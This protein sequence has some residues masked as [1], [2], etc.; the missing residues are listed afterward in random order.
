MIAKGNHHAHG[1]KLADYL[2]KADR[3]ERAELIETRGFGVCDLRMGFLAEQT[4]AKDGTKAEKPFFHAQ[5]RGAN[6]EGLKLSQAQWLEIADRC[7]KVL[8]LA[9]QPRA[10]SLHINRK[11]GD[12]HLHLGYSLVAEKENGQ[13]YVKKLGLHKLKLQ[14]L[15]RE[16]ERDYGLQIVRD[17][18]RGAKAPNRREFEESRRLGTSI[19]DIRGAI[20]SAFEKSD[21]GKS[22]AAAMQAQGFELANGDRRDCLVVV[23]H[24][25]GQHALNKKLTGKT[26]AEIQQ[27]LGDLDR[28]QLPSVDQ[29][30]E[31]QALRQGE[32]EKRQERA[33]TRDYDRGGNGP[34]NSPTPS[35]GP[36]NGRSVDFKPPRD[37]GKTAGEIRIAWRLT[38]TGQQFAHEIE[39]RGLILV[40]VSRADAD[41]SHRA[42]NFAKSINRESRELREGFAVV[43]RRGTVT[44]IDQRTTGDQWEEI[45]KRLGGINAAEL[46]SVASARTIMRDFNRAEWAELKQGERFTRHIPDAESR[47]AGNHEAFAAALAKDGGFGLVRVTAAD[48]RA[49][50]DLRQQQ[51]VAAAADEKHTPQHFGRVKEGEI[52]VV[53]KSGE[54]YRLDQKHIAGFAISSAALPSV[55]ELRGSFET[56]RQLAADFRRTMIDIQLQ[57]R[58]DAA[59]ERSTVFQERAANQAVRSVVA[60]AEKAATAP[61]KSAEKITGKGFDFGSKAIMAVAEGAIKF[62]DG[63]FS[64][65]VKRSAEQVKND[66]RA[67]DE[68]R[69]I[70]A[71]VAAYQQ[72]ETRRE[73]QIARQDEEN[74]QHLSAP[75]YF[76]TIKRPINRNLDRDDGNERERERER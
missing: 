27:R 76:R 6:G 11:T 4:R 34:P 66:A 28:A 43:D 71:D 17:E 46:M 26:L 20:L 64:Q 47:T 7:D 70:D 15:A 8:G 10:V 60:K 1:V 5:F 58:E 19:K 44:R 74:T 69:E 36:K 61:I 18:R 23:D 33:Q 63:L 3:G 12:K 21:N 29:A 25:G 32:R 59:N 67:A 49:L 41:A 30:K 16:I 2:M 73:E 38:G 13:G 50:D 35:Q 39:S 54:V 14:E 22:F 53:T 9:G 68:Q 24:A 51:Q 37:L 42:K 65:P 40:H 72:N 56:E 75:D 31:V 62:L 52:A 57:R 55:I 45:Q 48:I